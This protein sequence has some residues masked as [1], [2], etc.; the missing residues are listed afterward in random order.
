MTNGPSSP[1][2]GAASAMIRSPMCF[3]VGLVVL[4]A[5]AAALAQQ[6][7]RDLH[8]DV[9]PEGAV[10]RLGTV[11]MRHGHIICGVVFAGDGKSI[12]AADYDNGVHVW[13]AATGAEVGHY[14]EDGR[15]QCLDLSPDGRTLAVALGDLSIHLYDPSSGREFA[16][17]TRDRDRHSVLVF[18]PDGALLATRPGGSS[19]SVWNVT[20][21]QLF[22]EIDFDHHVGHVAFSSDGKLLACDVNNG[23]VFWDLAQRK[24]VRE[25]KNDPD[26]KHSLHAG[27]APGGGPLAVWGYEDA[28]IRLFDASGVKEIRRFNNEGGVGKPDS[29]GWAYR[30]RVR[31]SPDGKILAASR[32]PGRITLWDV[33]SG[34]KLHSLALDSSHRASFLAFSPD[35]TRL[36]SAGSDLWGGDHTVRVWDVARGK[37]LVPRAGHGA[38]ISSIAISP[39]GDVIATAGQDGIVH[40]WDRGTGRHLSRLEGYPSRRVRVA[41]SGDGRQVVSW[42]AFDADGTLRIWEAKTG[43]LLNRF[44]LPGDDSFWDTVSDDG[45][46]AVSVDLKAKSSRFHDLTT[47]KVT[48]EIADGAYNPP[49]ALSPTGKLMVCSDGHLRTMADRKELVEVGRLG[50]PTVSVRFSADGGRLAAAVVERS[51]H[52]SYLVDPQADEIALIDSIEGRELRR[53]GMRPG[54]HGAIDVAALSSDGKTV[55]ITGR[56]DDGSDEQLITLW[57]ADTGRERGYFRGHRGTLRGLAISADGRVIVSGGDDTAALV[58]DATRPLTQ[59][60]VRRDASPADLPARFAD[61]A[62]DDAEQAYASIWALAGTPKAA[63][64]FLAEQRSLFAVTDVEKIRRWIRNF[65]S[66]QFA[67]RDRASRELALVLDEAEPHLKQALL[68]KPSAEARRRTDVLLRARAAAPTGRELQRLRVIELLDR[69][70]TAEAIAILKKLAASVPDSRV[71]KEAKAVLERQASA[72]P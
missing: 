64:A 7:R 58:W 3:A 18:S 39:G 67:D 10:A 35:G 43:R 38:P 19:V 49:A 5:A 22:Q 63:V 68:A 2:K 23:I 52:K 66:S 56:S 72:R 59:G 1:A 29:W 26:G 25:L 6:P 24:V 17:L 31:F 47:G 42:G 34:K 41:F 69:I 32:E 30:F 11:R 44:K 12:I 9:L 54:R 57:E 21:R 51:P 14:L 13:D 62:G 50:M 20:T 16:A 37:E 33:A 70:G 46:T 40:L 27:F 28:S 65:D 71:A 48:R 55:V 4:S 60:K 45:K 53:F 61:L 15:C 8:G 36:A